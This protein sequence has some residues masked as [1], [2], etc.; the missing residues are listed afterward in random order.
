MCPQGWGIM[1]Y[2]MSFD[3]TILKAK[4]DA[5]KKAYESG[6]FGDALVGALNTG[7]GLMQ[8]RVFQNN[9]DVKGQSFGEYI[10]KKRKVRLVVSENRTQNKRNKAIAGLDLTSYQRKRAAKGR[11]ILK[12]DLE[13]TGGVRRAIETQIENEKSVVLQFNNDQAARIAR[14]QE[15]QIHNIRAGG[16]GTTKGSGA[17][18]IF[19]FD[20][21]EREQVT[22]QGAELIKQILKP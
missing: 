15:Q 19:T 13:F 6:R 18:R 3:I 22:E 21:K 8:Q 17:T 9:T 5:I 10:G 1:G 12:K 11:Q 7:S 16:K 2:R 14:G 4:I 20:E